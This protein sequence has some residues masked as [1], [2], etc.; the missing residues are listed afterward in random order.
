M[1]RLTVLLLLAL[2]LFA[3]GGC[4]DRLISDDFREIMAQESASIDE[5][6]EITDEYEFVSA[7][8]MYI[9]E[10]CGY[11][12]NPDAL[13]EPEQVFY[14]TQTLETEINCGGFWQ[15]FFNADEVVF[16]GATGAFAEIGAE[17]T[18]AICEE[19]I[20]AFPRELPDD[21]ESRMETLMKFG[22]EEGCELLSEFDD[23]FYS[24]EE[25]L[26][27]LNYAYVQNHKDQF[28]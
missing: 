13:S 3:T 14:I 2:L 12:S 23:R 7:M 4:T 16:R 25:D 18:A 26:N 6:W 17:K 20:A 5:I 10:K 8:Y 27:A 21:R 24:Y 11:G 15:F 22:M 9:A 19:A 1:K 28:S